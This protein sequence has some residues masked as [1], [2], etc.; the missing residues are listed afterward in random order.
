MGMFNV[1][2][3]SKSE[4]LELVLAQQK[5]LERL[6]SEAEDLKEEVSAKNRRI[7][8]I[9]VERLE[10][11]IMLLKKEV[12]SKDKRIEELLEMAQVT[13]RLIQLT[14]ILERKIKPGNVIEDGAE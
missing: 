14:R 5:E 2:K 12:E 4:L 9:V 7:D 1:K 3:Q 6:E 10:N 11:E 8:E 13:N